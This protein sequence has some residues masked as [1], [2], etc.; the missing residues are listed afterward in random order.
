MMYLEILISNYPSNHPALQWSRYFYD[1]AHAPVLRA[2][3]KVRSSAPGLFFA[4]LQRFRPPVPP[5][6]EFYANYVTLRLKNQKLKFAH[7]LLK[8]ILLHILFNIYFVSKIVG[9]LQTCKFNY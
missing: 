9:T 7:I 3:F 4:P 2:Y 1:S 8:M 5:T 6:R